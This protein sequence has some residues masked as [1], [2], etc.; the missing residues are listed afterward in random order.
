MTAGATALALQPAARPRPQAQPKPRQVA[1]ARDLHVVPTP[2]RQA[3]PNWIYV[4]LAGTVLALG[5]LGIVTLNALAAEASFEARSLERQITD[6]TL[7]HDDLVA[8]VAT[9]ASPNRV[10]EVATT[11]LGLIEPEQPGFLT[12]H[13]DD[14]VPEQPKAPVRLGE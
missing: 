4:A 5:V 11:Q 12:L 10:Q 8:A 13:P 7:R 1:P 14:L 9:L 6:A 3:L 2:V